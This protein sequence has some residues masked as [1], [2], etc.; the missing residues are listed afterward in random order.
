M[1]TS[2]SRVK[3]DWQEDGGNWRKEEPKAKASRALLSLIKRFRITFT[4][5]GK[6]QIDV[7][8]FSK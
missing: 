8:N 7:Q 2:G 6:R 5:N 1:G 4:A 3:G